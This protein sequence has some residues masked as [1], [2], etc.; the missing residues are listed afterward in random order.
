VSLYHSIG[1]SKKASTK[2]ITERHRSMWRYYRKHMRGN[3]AI[4]AV[5]AAGI[6]GRCG[7]LLGRHVVMDRGRTLVDAPAEQA[8]LAPPR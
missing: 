5:T 7:L 3:P 8:V 2:L 1:V 6:A 4:D